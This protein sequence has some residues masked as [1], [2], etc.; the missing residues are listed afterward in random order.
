MTKDKRDSVNSTL[1]LLDTIEEGDDNMSASD[2]G[3]GGC[4]IENQD[5]ID[6]ENMNSSKSNQ[7]AY[8]DIVPGDGSESGPR[9]TLNGTVSDNEESY[10]HA[11]AAWF[12]SP[13]LI[14]G[15]GHKDS[16]ARVLLSR[17]RSSVTAEDMKD[18]HS[19]IGRNSSLRSIGTYSSDGTGRQRPLMRRGSGPVR[20]TLEKEY[21]TKGTPN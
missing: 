1:G 16:A 3:T 7:R 12:L 2:T 21:E 13:I 6:V 19:E 17:K 9:R 15:G 4:D 11:L 8:V 14:L 10:Y 20:V 5:S 18:L